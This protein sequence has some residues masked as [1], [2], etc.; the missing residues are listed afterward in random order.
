M[1]NQLTLRA[2]WDSVNV[3]L[4]APGPQ[5]T[6]YISSIGWAAG[7]IAPPN[8]ACQRPPLGPRGYTSSPEAGLLTGRGGRVPRPVVGCLLAAFKVGKGGGGGG[9]RSGRGGWLQDGRVGR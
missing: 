1:S 8:S 9:G 4:P 2:E 7:D 5:A 3:W 6:R